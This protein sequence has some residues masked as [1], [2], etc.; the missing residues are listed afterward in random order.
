[1]SQLEELQRRITAALD[2]IGQG[3]DQM[4]DSAGADASEMETLRQDLEDEK[5][6]NEQLKERVRQLKKRRALLEERVGEEEAQNAAAL[7]RLDADLQSL[8]EA[9]QQLR[10][11][12][13]ALREANE[14]GV[15][16]PHLINK[17]MLAELEALRATRTADRT[18]TETILSQ[19]TA[20][21]ESVDDGGGDDKQTE[22][23]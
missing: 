4:P 2:R 14:A 1:M 12:N 19:L 10:E 13:R 8:R 23:A 17:A 15:A 16:E 22:D 18:E 20:A 6:A 9:N 7:A 3:L 11:I 21:I 5:V